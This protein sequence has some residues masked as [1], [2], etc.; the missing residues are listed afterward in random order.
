MGRINLG[1][2]RQGESLQSITMS[3]SDPS[4][5]SFPTPAGTGSGR[6]QAREFHSTWCGMT[7]P[8]EVYF[9]ISITHRPAVFQA[10]GALW[11]AEGS[12]RQ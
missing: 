3:P 9:L 5:L 8:Q 6:K 11:A 2:W 12:C 4:F 1:F 7:L 10:D